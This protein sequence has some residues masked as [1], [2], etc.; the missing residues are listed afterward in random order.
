MSGGTVGFPFGRPLYTMAKSAGAACNLGCKY[1]YYLEKP[2]VLAYQ[3]PSQMM[4]DELLELFIRQ[5]IEAQTMPEVSF[6]WHGGEPL[7]RPISFYEK[8]LS[9]QLRY[10]GGRVVSNSIQTNGTLFTDEWC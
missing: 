10:A 5:Y 2:S 9:L 6:P 1:C 4:S 8:A 3:E 7:L